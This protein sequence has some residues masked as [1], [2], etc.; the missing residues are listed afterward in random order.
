MAKRKPEE[1][2]A[3]A[4]WLNTFADLMNLLLC[5]FVLL[6]SMSTIDAQKFEAIAASLSESF[7]IFSGGATALGE[8]ILIS[9]GVSQLNELDQ[10][11]NSMG[12]AAEDSTHDDIMGE[13]Q[14]SQ[15]D[16]DASADIEQA[17]QDEL[18]AREDK[19]LQ[20]S[21]E[22]AEII[23]E[24]LTEQNLDEA[25][26][27][28]FTSQYVQLTLNGA[29]LFDSGSATIKKDALP[30]LDKI[31][32]ILQK[33]SNEEIEIE[34]HTDNVPISGRFANNNELSSARALSV[35]EYLMDHTTLNPATVK[36]TGRGE[37][38]PVADNSTPEGRAQN[39]R[40]EI[41]IYHTVGTN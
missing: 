6:F 14:A 24:M 39:R 12:K 38:I 15:N 16:T 36:H 30:I 21:E 37:Y 25:V 27:I 17:V 20:Q 31:G 1:P 34:G 2:K 40:V 35:F 11:L 18:Q 33:Y 7:S 13:N 28:D 9:N 19:Q 32:V 23:Q 5:F 10:Y 29:L 4:A 8:G 22:M 3:G 41:K 26:D